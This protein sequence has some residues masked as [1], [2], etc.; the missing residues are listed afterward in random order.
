LP[1]AN[2]GGR[3]NCRLS[4]IAEML[5]LPPLVTIAAAGVQIAGCRNLA[6]YA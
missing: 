5:Q 2:C 4:Q 3:A 1:I 6:Q